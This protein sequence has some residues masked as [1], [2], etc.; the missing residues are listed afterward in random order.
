MRI[1]RCT[2]QSSING[3]VAASAVSETVFVLSRGK[4][5]THLGEEHGENGQTD[6]VDDAGKLE[7]IINCREKTE[8]HIFKK[9]FLFLFKKCVCERLPAAK[10]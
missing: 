9:R 8:E 5:E 6:P 7:C 2:A 3:Q 1:C 4:I 10:R